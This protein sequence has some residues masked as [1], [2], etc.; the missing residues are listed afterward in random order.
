MLTALVLKCHFK[1][2]EVKSFV[3]DIDILSLAKV[4]MEYFECK[5]DDIINF[6]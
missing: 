5:W 4:D 2:Q 6:G 3:M 1:E